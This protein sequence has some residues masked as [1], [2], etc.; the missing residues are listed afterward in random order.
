MNEGFAG[1]DL[2]FARASS[3]VPI[4]LGVACLSKPTWLSLICRKL[5]LLGSAASA[6]S[7]IPSERGT[8]PETVHK[9]PVPAHVM[10]SNTLRRLTSVSLI[11]LMI[12]LRMDFGLHRR[13]LRAGAVY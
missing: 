12:L 4:T 10:H 2:T 11:S 9:T 5:S 1:S 3:S 7:M 13:R 8:P 6:P